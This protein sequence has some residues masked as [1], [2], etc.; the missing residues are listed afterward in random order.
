VRQR[1][2]SELDFSRQEELNEYKK[3]VQAV[4]P[5]VGGAGAYSPGIAQFGDRGGAIEGGQILFA[6]TASHL[7]RASERSWQIT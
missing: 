2:S 1:I 6:T 4:A 3:L 5:L 7:G